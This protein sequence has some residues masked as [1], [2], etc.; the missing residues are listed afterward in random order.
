M[1]SRSGG[2][3]QSKKEAH[4]LGPPGSPWVGASESGWGRGRDIPGRQR[5]SKSQP[6]DTHQCNTRY[7]LIGFCP[8]SGSLV[9]PAGALSGKV[10]CACYGELP[11]IVI[12]GTSH[13][14][15]LIIPEEPRFGVLE[16]A[17]R[18]TEMPFRR[19]SC[20][21]KQPSKGA[22]AI[23]QTVS[24]WASQKFSDLTLSAT[25]AAVRS[26]VPLPQLAGAWPSPA[27]AWLSRGPLEALEN[28]MVQFQPQAPAYAR[29]V[30]LE[31]VCFLRW[32]CAQTP[33]VR[34]RCGS[35]HPLLR[36]GMSDRR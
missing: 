2:P 6:L 3:S 10:G 21:P 33:A 28:P 36:S 32:P 34:A 17:S 35:F 13:G 27:P 19:L 16:A 15:C 24:Y 12:S 31:G 9:P 29:S 5:R 30:P 23:Y 22:K 1:R 14:N 7:A 26:P 4:S 8:K 18:R 20:D 25:R 11:R